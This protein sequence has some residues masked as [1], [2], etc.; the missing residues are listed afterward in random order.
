MLGHL[1]VAVF[2]YERKFCLY[3]A[4]DTEELSSLWQYSRVVESTG[5]RFEP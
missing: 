2:N 4:E 3:G 1:T 5:R